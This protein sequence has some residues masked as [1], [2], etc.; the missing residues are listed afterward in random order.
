M[1]T[2]ESD[3]LEAVNEYGAAFKKLVAHTLA[4]VPGVS[5]LDEEYPIALAGTS[6]AVDIVAKT[7]INGR[8]CVLT[9]ECKRALAPYKKWV[10]FPE[11][12]TD[13]FKIGRGF[14][15]TTNLSFGAHRNSLPSMNFCS[16]GCEVLRKGNGY[17]ANPTAIYKASSQAAL[18][19]L[20]YLH[21][22]LPRRGIP[23]SLPKAPLLIVLPVVVTTA[24]IYL[25]STPA[26]RVDPKTGLL[27]NID[28]QPI[29]WLAYRFPFHPG[30]ATRDGDFRV[31][32]PVENYISMC[33][34]ADSS[35][36]DQYK[37]TIY[38][39]N[40]EHLRGFVYHQVPKLVEQAIDI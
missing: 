36:S 38:I 31:V 14:R 23:D 11:T 1:S 19:S 16:D 40:N 32:D 13:T 25:C 20:G 21:E 28:L 33:V 2:D 4:G 26:S 18:A 17:K 39:V 7:N 29:Q 24:E 6:S 37:E 35:T 5:V 9:C 27:P 34:D 3:I 30:S 12:H 10:F 22:R 15:A 8:I